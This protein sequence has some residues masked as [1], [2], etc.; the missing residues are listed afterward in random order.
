MSHCPNCNA[1]V[2][3]DSR[4]C[5][6]C[7]FVIIPNNSPDDSVEQP[8]PLTHRRRFGFSSPPSA[9]IEPTAQLQC[10]RC[11]AGLTESQ[12]NCAH[13]GEPTAFAAK[14]AEFGEAEP[15]RFEDGAPTGATIMGFILGA[16]GIIGSFMLWGATNWPFPLAV[17]PLLALGYFP[18]KKKFSKVAR[19]Y[20]FA[21]LTFGILVGGPFLVCIAIPALSSWMRVWI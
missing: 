5:P 14:H 21:L 4:V 3:G 7:G 1:D 15:L 8:D 9:G 19:G 2:V 6:S 16:V 12:F 11:G 18:F 10:L 17:I 13:C 20:G